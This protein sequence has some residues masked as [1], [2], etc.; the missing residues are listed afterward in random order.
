VL[1][2]SIGKWDISARTVRTRLVTDIR[3]HIIAAKEMNNAKP[4][5]DGLDKGGFD[6]GGPLVETAVFLADTTTDS[7]DSAT[8]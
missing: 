2:E 7:H 4:C 8:T 1:A 5:S 6:E 3:Q